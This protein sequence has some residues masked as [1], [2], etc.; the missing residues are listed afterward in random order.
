MCSCAACGT[1]EVCAVNAEWR[2][3]N[4]GIFFIEQL[5]EQA[6]AWSCV[7]LHP[8]QTRE[9]PSVVQALAWLKPH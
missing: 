4:Y 7:G 1:L 5:V 2:M 9:Q 8:R 3:E 6:L